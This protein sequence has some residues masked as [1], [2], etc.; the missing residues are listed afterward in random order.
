MGPQVFTRLGTSSP[1]KA[2]P[3]SLLQYMCL[4]PQTSLC[5]LPGWW[6]SLWHLPG[7]G[8]SW[9]SGLPMELPSLSTPSVLCL[10]IVLLM[11][12]NPLCLLHYFFLTCHCADCRF[13]LLSGEWFVGTSPS[14]LCVTRALF[15]C[16]VWLCFSLFLPF[17]AG[18]SF[19][20]YY[21]M[22]QISMRK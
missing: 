17:A 12:S 14:K 5:I 1:T 4:G 10:I 19:F 16:N 6:L 3:G 22:R 8:V 18:G 9:N 21:W 2:K 13:L 7:V 15:L 20:E 11:C